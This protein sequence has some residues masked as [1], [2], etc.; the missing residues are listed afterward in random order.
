M[1][2][3]NAAIFAFGGINNQ[4]KQESDQVWRLQHKNNAW[5]WEKFRHALMTARSQHTSIVQ[6]SEQ[7]FKTCIDY[8]ISGGTIIHI[9]GSGENNYEVWE[10]NDN[11]WTIRQ[12]KLNLQN[13]IVHPGAFWVNEDE[14]TEKKPQ[15]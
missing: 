8:I 11:V 12:T 13:W 7:D 3:G 2:Y 10:N 5:K 14:F 1:N 15:L 9:G 4:D 6:G